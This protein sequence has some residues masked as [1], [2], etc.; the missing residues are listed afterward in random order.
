MKLLI[1]STSVLGIMLILDGFWLGVVAKQ[2]YSSHI[3]HLMSSQVN[4]GAAILFYL[5]F[6]L[7]LIFLILLPHQNATLGTI[8]L[9]A[10]VFGVVCYGTY[11]LTNMATLKNWPLIVTVVDMVWGATITTVTAVGAT[12]IS[13]FFG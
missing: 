13:R 11:D 7:S 2:F 5:L 3:G 9:Y 10:A 8:A 4:W 6:A 12:Y 1:L